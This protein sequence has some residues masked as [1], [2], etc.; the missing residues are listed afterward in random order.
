MNPGLLGGQRAAG[1]AARPHDAVAKASEASESPENLENKFAPHSPTDKK[2]LE[3][4]ATAAC[5]LAQA[6]FEVDL[7]TGS[8]AGD[9]DVSELS[10]DHGSLTEQDPTDSIAEVVDDAEAT[11]DGTSPEQPNTSSSLP[12][13]HKVDGKPGS[14]HD[15]TECDQI[16]PFVVMG[17]LPDQAR[18]KA[19]ETEP[20]AARELPEARE[21]TGAD[22][23]AEVDCQGKTKRQQQTP[24]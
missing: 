16:C 2:I 23:V 3:A 17:S 12:Y 21:A 24:W 8:P 9:F 19:V 10:Q 5:R 6:A 20:K 11:Q 13:T 15:G 22:A 7:K 1:A 14:Y 18:D 4:D